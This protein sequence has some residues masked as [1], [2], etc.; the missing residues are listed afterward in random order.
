MSST[1]SPSVETSSAI[2]LQEKLWYEEDY[3]DSDLQFSDDD[4]I[5]TDENDFSTDEDDSDTNF[6]S[7]SVTNQIEESLQWSDFDSDDETDDSEIDDD[8]MDNSETEATGLVNQMTE[9]SFYRKVTK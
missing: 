9:M 5:W 6:G 7:E 3:S 8:E 2:S 4:D 1:S